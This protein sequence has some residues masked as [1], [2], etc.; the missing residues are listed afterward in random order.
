MFPEL[1]PE[2]L[3]PWIAVAAAVG[4]ILGQRSAGFGLAPAFVVQGLAFIL[5]PWLDHRPLWSQALLTLLV[6]LLLMRAAISIVFGGRVADGFAA[7][8]VIRIVDLLI[9]GPLRAVAFLL[10][11]LIR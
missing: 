3:L 7:Q 2:W 9:V 11:L 1:I 8:W 5:C 4:F 6:W 10:R